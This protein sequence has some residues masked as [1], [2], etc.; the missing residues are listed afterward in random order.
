M[1]K[2][3]V[4]IEK[5]T[6]QETLVIP[7]Y[8]RKMCTEQFPNLF[9]DSKAVELIDSLDYDN[10]TQKE[11]R[12]LVEKHVKEVT[13]EKGVMEGRKVIFVHVKTSRG[14]VNF[15]YFNTLKDRSKQ[16]VRIK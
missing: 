13:L 6:V 15:A 11:K 16:I 5:N 12:V 10:L 3:K 4:H 9:Q 7:L 8:G 1:S 2:P 14:K